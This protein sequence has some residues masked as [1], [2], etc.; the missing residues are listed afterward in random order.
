[1]AREPLVLDTED[2]DHIEELLETLS[3][4]YHVL[5]PDEEKRE[6]YEGMHK[7]LQESRP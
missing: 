4:G 3:E 1:M 5:G 2:L 6:Q 7:R